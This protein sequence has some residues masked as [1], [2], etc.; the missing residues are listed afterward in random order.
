MTTMSRGTVGFG[1]GGEH[2]AS[3]TSA[4]EALGKSALEHLGHIFIQVTF[5]IENPLAAI[6]VLI[7][8]SAALQ[9]I[10]LRYGG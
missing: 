5:P 7:V 3:S 10:S 1:T 2:P 8:L 9:S 4:L 6:V